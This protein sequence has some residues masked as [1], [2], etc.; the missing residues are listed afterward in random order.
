MS[1]INQAKNNIRRIIK[2]P[3]RK[4]VSL[5]ETKAS[6]P[7]LDKIYVAQEYAKFFHQLKRDYKL[8]KNE[9]R[10]VAS[11]LED[12]LNK[13]NYIQEPWIPVPWNALKKSC[14]SVANGSME[15]LEQ[16]GLLVC[17][18]EWS[19]SR[20][21]CKYYQPGSLLLDRYY[22]VQFEIDV[23]T[24]SVVSLTSQRA[25]KLKHDMGQMS[26]LTRQAVQT[27]RFNM[28][29]YGAMVDWLQEFYDRMTA[30]NS[31]KLRQQYYQIRY[32]LTRMKQQ[33]LKV[34]ENGI[35][36]YTP[37]YTSCSTGRIIEIG[38][39]QGMM[40]EL[41][42]VAYD[43]PGYQV[44]NYDLRSSQIAAALDLFEQHVRFYPELKSYIKNRQAKYVFAEKANMPVDV[45]KTCMTCLWF[46]GR[47]A[48]NKGSSIYRE[49]TTYFKHNE[50][51]ND[52]PEAMLERFKLVAKP[53]I[54]ISKEWME[55]LKTT[56]LSEYRIKDGKHY[57]VENHCGMVLEVPSPENK[58]KS[59]F[60]RKFSS[61]ILQGLECSCI[62]NLMLI[63]DREGYSV[64]SNE[65]DG[66]ILSSDQS[67]RFDLIDEAREKSEFYFY[68]YL[69]R[70]EF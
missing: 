43:I 3:H 66:L 41:K 60:L 21:K 27:I 2:N 10:V 14:S 50:V 17:D 69:E 38:G 49:I 44:W 12:Y 62:Q 58:V 29:N 70:K 23:L 53:F 47:I 20:H 5:E 52:S 56:F 32:N 67:L 8:T 6:I 4:A 64:L 40:K 26:D 65:H 63:C 39:M 18:H 48:R 9:L 25:P 22:E 7:T 24:T 28:C 68:S 36:R 34:D 61:F 31:R 57:Y 45:W 37:A 46:G 35:A 13:S 54:S 19:Q 11:I 1:V 51:E 15:N 59:E 42:R 30:T 55:F 33:G 16:Y